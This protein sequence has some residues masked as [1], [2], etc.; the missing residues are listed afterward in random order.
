MSVLFYPFHSLLLK[1][2]N[3]GMDFLF[4]TLKLPNKGMKEY[5]KNIIFI[6]FHSLFPNK[7]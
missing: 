7:S 1:L 4:P 5:F 6:L 3:K 2:P